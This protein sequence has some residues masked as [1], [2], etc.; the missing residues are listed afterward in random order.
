M[1][2]IIEV[3]KKLNIELKLNKSIRASLAYFIVLFT[4]VERVLEYN[5]IIFLC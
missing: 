2:S 4:G 1:Q 5:N 3:I